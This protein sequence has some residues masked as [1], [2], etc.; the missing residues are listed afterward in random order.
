MRTLIDLTGRKFGRWTALY[1]LPR[2]PSR[3][4]TRHYQCAC[5]CG[6]ERAVSYANLT[7]GVTKSCGCLRREILIQRQTKHGQS[8]GRVTP[9]YACW[10]SLRN[11][12]ANPNEQ[13][14]HLYGGRGITVCERWQS[15]E[16]FLAD[17]GE[18]PSDKHSIDRIDNDG[19]Y[20]PGNCRWATLTEQNNNNRRNVL[21]EHNG[22]IQTVAQWAEE[23]GLSWS[24]I[25]KRL[26]RG[27]SGS[28]AVTRPEVTVRAYLYNGENLTI[29]EWSKRIGV[30]P[31]ALRQRL[32]NGMSIE[33]ALTRPWGRWAG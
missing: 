17:M 23:T 12:C 26:L 18:R 7:S 3:P 25:R 32:R 5:A 8:H 2:F 1:E 24:A 28:D 20:E 30:T 6:A 29:A 14:Y 11:R 10:K 15:F 33:D 27:M 19:N 31:S 21:I 4:K 13:Y 16:N 22:R 9:T